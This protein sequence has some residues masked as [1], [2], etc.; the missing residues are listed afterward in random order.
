[1]SDPVRQ[2]SEAMGILPRYT[3]QTGLV[4]ETDRETAAA[5][6]AAMGAEAATEGQAADRLAAL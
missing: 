1:M 4:R 5:L 6:L 3:D 2:L